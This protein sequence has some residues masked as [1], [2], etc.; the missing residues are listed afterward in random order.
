[1]I[2]RPVLGILRTSFMILRPVL[3][4]LRPVLRILRTI[5]GI[6]WTIHV[7]YI[8]ITTIY[9]DCC[10]EPPRVLGVVPRGVS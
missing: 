5:L 9:E 4:I 2:V 10:C 1:M 7:L 3:R 6:L 8:G